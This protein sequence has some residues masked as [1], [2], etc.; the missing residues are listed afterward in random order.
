MRGSA[1]M[2]DQ[3]TAFN[4]SGYTMDREG[5][6]IWPFRSLHRRWSDLDGLDI[7]T[8]QRN[9]N[10]F[11]CL[12][13]YFKASR[14]KTIQ[15]QYRRGMAGLR[16][17][18]RTVRLVR[19][20]RPD[21]SF[22][23]AKVFE[24]FAQE[25]AAFD[26][27][28]L[29]A[30]DLP[31][32]SLLKR[33]EVRLLALENEAAVK[34]ATILIT[35]RAS[36]ESRAA[37]IKIKAE[38]AQYKQEDA[39]DTLDDLLHRHPDE[40]ESRIPVTEALLA[41]GNKRGAALAAT[42]LE[43]SPGAHADL[44]FRLAAYW[45]QQRKWDEARDLL[46]N[47]AEARPDLAGDEKAGLEQMRAELLNLQAKPGRAFK[48][49]TLRPFW[50]RMRVWI[51]L[52]F[53]AAGFSWGLWK[54][55][56]IFARESWHLWELR[57]HGARADVAVLNNEPEHAVRDAF[58]VIMS[59]R[60]APDRSKVDPFSL[61]GADMHAQVEAEIKTG[62]ISTLAEFQQGWYQGAAIVFEGT[63]R[64]IEGNPALQYVTYLP[65]DPTVS[66]I[67]PITDTRIWLTWLGTP[68][69]F[70]YPIVLVV[71]VAIPVLRAFYKRRRRRWRGSAL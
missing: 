24:Q 16:L 56:P 30:K 11:Y 70:L 69:V 3:N 18:I 13:F 28:L 2:M 33:A 52:L 59:Y 46:D 45:A 65:A 53:I 35:R 38:L 62:K 60:Y 66:T 27:A 31:D 64:D 43:H 26:D 10:F 42:V 54:V 4:A 21:L 9:G 36:C 67:G 71:A 25:T 6:H 7:L 37:A 8:V 1:P 19:T 44:V 34:D 23:Q 48:D 39:I 61:P 63:A 68:K 58:I 57:E 49:L 29:K 41:Q 40:M 12:K 47:L 51:W 15:I 17:V 32:E 50:G 5:I 22:L 55:T 14:L 20:V